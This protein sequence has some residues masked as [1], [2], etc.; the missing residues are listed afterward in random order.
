MRTSTMDPLVLLSMGNTDPCLLPTQGNIAKQGEEGTARRGQEEVTMRRDILRK[1]S[2]RRVS[3]QN[4]STHRLC[5][6]QC[7]TNDFRPN[8]TD[9]QIVFQCHECRLCR[10]IC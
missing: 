3:M 6:H 5:L 4:P 10:N 7:T 9:R 1:A 2:M 8:I